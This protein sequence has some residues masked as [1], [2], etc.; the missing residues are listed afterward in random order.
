MA[1]ENIQSNK[2][3]M[4]LLLVKFREFLMR[5]SSMNFQSGNSSFSAFSQTLWSPA[6]TVCTVYLC[7][8]VKVNTV[9]IS[10][11]YYSYT[12][13]QGQKWAL[14]IFQ[15]G[16][17]FTIA[18]VF[19][20]IT[21][22]LIIQIQIQHNAMLGFWGLPRLLVWFLVIHITLLPKQNTKHKIW[23]ILRKPVSV[24]SWKL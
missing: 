5:I 8:S 11:V 4:N 13:T 19:I 7:I 3:S 20:A 14:P 18:G 21:T 23:H 12:H 6:S 22:I 9:C 15:S 24:F 16:L 10:N 1:E 17:I 2:Y